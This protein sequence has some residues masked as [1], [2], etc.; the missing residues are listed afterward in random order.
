MSGVGERIALVKVTRQEDGVA[1]VEMS[2]GGLS[3]VPGRARVG[4]KCLWLWFRRRKIYF[5]HVLHFAYDTRESRD[6][7]LIKNLWN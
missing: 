1:R 7:I 4:Y 6:G 5:T 2:W 3:F